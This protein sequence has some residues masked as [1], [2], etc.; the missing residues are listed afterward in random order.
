MFLKSLHAALQENGLS[1]G[2][3]RTHQL[4]LHDSRYTHRGCC[5]VI[6]PFPQQ[7][8]AGCHQTGW[9]CCLLFTHWLSFSLRSCT[10]QAQS[11]T[12]TWALPLAPRKHQ[13]PAPILSQLWA[14]P[15][16]GDTSCSRA[17]LR[18]PWCHLPREGLQ[19]TGILSSQTELGTETAHMFH[20]P[21]GGAT[22]QINT[23]SPAASV[24][25]MC[26]SLCGA[27]S[28]II[29]LFL[30]LM[31]EQQ[32]TAYFRNNADFWKKS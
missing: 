29:S 8:K 3:R 25:W 21:I 24:P 2:Q 28:S 1:T 30:T 4:Q 10:Q 15:D 19:G 23:G 12:S 11:C 17:E 26:H 20:I 13:R 5:R 27:T 18:V 31:C 22:L 32:L 6:P 9:L 7:T 16:R 14:C